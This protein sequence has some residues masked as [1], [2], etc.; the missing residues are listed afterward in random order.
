MFYY[1]LTAHVLLLKTITK[2]LLVAGDYNAQLAEQG[3][4]ADKRNGKLVRQFARAADLHLVPQTNA[5]FIRE[6][7]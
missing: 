1:Y 2:K 4:T 3:H 5:T 7:R 6:G